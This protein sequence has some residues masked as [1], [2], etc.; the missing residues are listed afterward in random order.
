L[1]FAGKTKVFLSKLLGIYS[2]IWGSGGMAQEC[3]F[4]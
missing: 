2:P 3:H 4:I 1:K